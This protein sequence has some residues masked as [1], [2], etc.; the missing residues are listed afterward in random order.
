M[1][2]TRFEFANVVED[3]TKH[4]AKWCH[5]GFETSKC[6]MGLFRPDV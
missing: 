4:T 3:M 6:M 2:Q 5:D 1:N